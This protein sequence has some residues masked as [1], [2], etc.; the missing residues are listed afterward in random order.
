MNGSKL[1]RYSTSEYQTPYTY[2]IL[3][4]ARLTPNRR[5]VFAYLVLM[6][7]IITVK[8]LTYVAHARNTKHN[9]SVQPMT[10][11]AARGG[12][13]LAHQVAALLAQTRIKTRFGIGV[14]YQTVL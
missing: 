8:T 6:W 4:K 9:W 7:H 5:K 1:T 13:T 11:I 3:R 10:N 2:V 14:A 12:C